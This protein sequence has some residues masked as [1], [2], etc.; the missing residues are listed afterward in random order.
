MNRI[1]AL[2]RFL[3]LMTF[4]WVAPIA[5]AQSLPSDGSQGTAVEFTVAPY[6]LFPTMSG[7]MTVRGRDLEVDLGPSEIFE[8]LELGLMGYFEVRKGPW[9][10]AFDGL[11]MDL[12]KSAQLDTILGPVGATLGLQQG[13]YEFTGIRTVAPWADM[14]FG[15]RIN[16][17]SGS[18]ETVLL[19]LT[20]DSSATWVDPFVGVRLFVPETGNWFA[21]V[22]VDIGGFGVGSSFAWQIYPTVGYNFVDWFTLAGGFRFLDMNYETGEASELFVYDMSIYGPVVGFVFRF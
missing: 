14:V 20:G 16:N 17:I 11:Y 18:F 10:F 1:Q 2:A 6:L 15:V 8:N 4:L 9:A 3:T 5:H 19:Q 7:N 22:R 13:M 12:A 21:G